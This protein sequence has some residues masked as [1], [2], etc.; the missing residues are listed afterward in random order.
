MKKHLPYEQNIISF[1]AQG[2]YTQINSLNGS[3]SIYAKTLKKI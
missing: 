2:N 1:F 3:V